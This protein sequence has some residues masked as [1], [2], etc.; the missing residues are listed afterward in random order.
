MLRLP[1][2]AYIQMNQAR[3]FLELHPE[4][5]G[6]RLCLNMNVSTSNASDGEQQSVDVTATVLVGRSSNPSEMHTLTTV[7]SEN[8]YSTNVQSQIVRLVGH[9]SSA[10]LRE[11]EEERAGGD[12]WFALTWMKGSFVDPSTQKLSETIGGS[13]NIAVRVRSG[14]WAEHLEKVTAAS[15]TDVLIPVTGDPELAIAAGR[16]RKAKALIR[17]GEF[18]AVGSELRQAVDRVRIFYGTDEAYKSA[19]AKKPTER[20]G[21]ERF[22]VYVQGLYSWLSAYV[23][24]D[25]EEIEGIELDYGTA[26]SALASVAGLLHQMAR[27]QRT[28]GPL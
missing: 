2:N 21:P 19:M 23:H 10:A 16:L 15:Y 20:S 13:P 24:D 25:N 17:S 5:D 6:A 14:E 3:D 4:L 28:D 18:S 27:D 1:S 8:L 22:A 26:T 12:L 7:R 11:L 9:V